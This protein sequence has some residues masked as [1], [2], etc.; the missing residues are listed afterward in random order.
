MKGRKLRL[1]VLNDLVKAVP[2]PRLLTIVQVPDGDGGMLPCIQNLHQHMQIWGT[3][4]APQ[5]DLL[6]VDIK[7]EQDGYAPDYFGQEVNPYGLL[8][9]LPLAARQGLTGMPFVWDI[10]T[11]QPKLVKD[12][13]VAQFAFGLLSA[14]EQ[15]E[16]GGEN[17]WKWNGYQATLSPAHFHD[18]IQGL[19]SSNPD[20]RLDELVTRYRGKLIEQVGAGRLW[21]DLSEI[22][23]LKAL[24]ADKKMVNLAETSLLIYCDDKNQPKQELFLQSL[25][26]DELSDRLGDG[27]AELEEWPGGGPCTE[28][29]SFVDK[30]EAAIWRSIPVDQLYKLVRQMLTELPA[31]SKK[32]LGAHLKGMRHKQF[33]LIGT[34]ICKWLELLFSGE[35]STTHENVKAVCKIYHD[36]AIA[37]NLSD[38]GINTTGQLFIDS[39]ARAPL[40]QPF[41]ALGDKHWTFLE[42]EA[43]RQKT[44]PACIEGQLAQAST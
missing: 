34:V 30:L 32:G 33:I 26:A 22:K 6:L 1:L 5:F 15:R 31:A 37:D 20:E 35:S 7:Y 24:L 41:R 43:K 2:K 12:D 10:H 4:C 11:G 44:R 16:V 39:L 42:Q 9:A 29:R 23:R 38:L 36:H 8:H 13:P 18:G 21:A 3:S 14:M 28:L 17:P 25:F 19:G 27:V 40:P